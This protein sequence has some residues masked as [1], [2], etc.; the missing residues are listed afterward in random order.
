MTVSEESD[1]G[2][3]EAGLLAADRQAHVL[4]LLR[5][6]GTVRVK[7]LAQS[8]GVSDMTIRRDL[9]ALAASGIAEKIHGGAKLRAG[10]SHDEPGF[11]AKQRRQG[12]EKA[13]IAAEAVKHVSAG[14]VVGLSAG[15][16]TYAFAQQLREVPGLTIVTNSIPVAEQ[17]R[18]GGQRPAYEGTVLI[19]GGERTL[20]DALVGPI[21]VSALRQLHVDLL[22]LGV[23]GA[24]LDAGLTTPNLLE[25]EVN[26]VFLAASNRVAVLAD[27]TKWGTVGMSSFAPLSAAA[28]FITDN[29]LAEHARPALREQVGELITVKVSP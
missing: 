18:G 16:T 29:G 21:A 19:T 7:E 23:H 3:E 15:T 13:A 14:M 8:F 12:A 25:S 20:S 26:Q 24:H 1:N 2:L 11:A 17:F 5:Q 6:R 10:L 28:L 4:S 22:F 27:H 9:D